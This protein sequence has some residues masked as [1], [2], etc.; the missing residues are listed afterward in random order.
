MKG[1]FENL[2]LTVH[3]KNQRERGK[4]IGHLLYDLVSVNGGTGGGKSFDIGR[5]AV[6]GHK[7]EEVGM[8]YYRPIRE[9]RQRTEK[10]V[11]WSSE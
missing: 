2:I 6:D 8:G 7:G 10:K 9:E 4:L 5:N 11:I 3:I 1:G